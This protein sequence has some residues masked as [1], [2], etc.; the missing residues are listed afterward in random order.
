[1][2]AQEAAT[3]MPEDLTG[4]AENYLI[5]V[6]EAA[7]RLGVSEDRVRQI[8][9]DRGI[10]TGLVGGRIILDERRLPELERAHEV[11]ARGSPRRAARSRRRWGR[12]RVKSRVWRVLG[13]AAVITSLLAFVRID[14]FSI[15]RAVAAAMAAG[16]GLI[17]WLVWRRDRRTQR[18]DDPDTSGALETGSRVRED[19]EATPQLSPFGIRLHGVQGLV[20]AM[21]LAVLLASAWMEDSPSLSE[22]NT[23]TGTPTALASA[24]P[25]ATATATLSSTATVTP[26]TTPTPTPPPTPTPEFVLLP[27]R[28]VLPLPEPPRNGRGDAALSPNRGGE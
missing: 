11:P 27:E 24:T 3:L 6:P 15:A 16:N 25:T 4:P 9:R 14:A 1:M 17:W 10:P 12:S 23:P 28:P 22:E 2:E 13:E 19:W 7:R 8:V 18:R 20:G 26:T 5:S 21:S